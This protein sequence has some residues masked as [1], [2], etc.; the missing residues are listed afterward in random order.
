MK[1]SANA[2]APKLAGGYRRSNGKETDFR[3]HTTHI[4]AGIRPD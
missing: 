1:I 3:A 2:E 4:D